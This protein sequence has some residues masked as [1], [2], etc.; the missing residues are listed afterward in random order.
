M[1]YCQTF[2]RGD[3][4][5]SGF[6]GEGIGQNLDDRRGLPVHRFEISRSLT[7]AVTKQVEIDPATWQ[8]AAEPV[9]WPLVVSVCSF[10]TEGCCFRYLQLGVSDW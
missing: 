6:V 1:Y 3:D 7:G 8:V 4:R 5:N 2:C 10:S 9:F